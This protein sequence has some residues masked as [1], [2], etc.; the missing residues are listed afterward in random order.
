M[1]KKVIT[2]QIYACMVHHRLLDVVWAFITC[3]AVYTTFSLK[4]HK[5]DVVEGN[6]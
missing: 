5:L 3:L 6:I 1:L 4:K 2:C